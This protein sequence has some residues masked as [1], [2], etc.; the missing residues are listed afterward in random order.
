ML[1]KIVCEPLLCRT[2]DTL[3]QSE[4]TNRV[5]CDSH[6]I[7]LS[8]LKLNGKLQNNDKIYNKPNSP[9]HCII[10]DRVCD[11]KPR[12]HRNNHSP[13]IRILVTLSVLALVGTH[14]FSGR[15]QV[16]AKVFVDEQQDHYTQVAGCS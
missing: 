4:E 15:L 12:N 5:G 1:R 2:C 10:Q 6:R 16:V 14:W 8:S 13:S 3:F 7:D 9:W 11:K